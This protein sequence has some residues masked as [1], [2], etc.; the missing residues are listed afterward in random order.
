MCAMG[1][2]EGW[3]CSNFN[4]TSVVTLWNSAEWK[5]RTGWHGNF[6]SSWQSLQ[7]FSGSK[8][9]SS[10]RLNDNREV[11]VTQLTIMASEDVTSR[12][13][14]PDDDGTCQAWHR[15][16]VSNIFHH[17]QHHCRCCHQPTLCRYCWNHHHE[18]NKE[19]NAK[20]GTSF[21]NRDS[22]APGLSCLGPNSPPLKSDK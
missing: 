16:V 1:G 21:N 6:K 11:K 19:A 7:M 8:C 12:S 3:Y 4:R 2:R 17:F 22:W 9:Q 15:R 14:V 20:K 5:L 10:R 18:T 13:A